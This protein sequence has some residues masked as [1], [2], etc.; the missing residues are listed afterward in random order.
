MASNR[1]VEALL[2]LWTAAG[3][4]LLHKRKSLSLTAGTQPLLSLKETV[5]LG[6]VVVVRMEIPGIASATRLYGSPDF[7]TF[8]SRGAEVSLVHEKDDLYRVENQGSNCALC[9]RLATLKGAPDTANAFFSDDY[10]TLLPGE[11]R[12]VNLIRKRG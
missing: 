3:Q 12:C 8:F 6:D 2:S 1:T 11:T 7:T 9:V 5:P 4:Q 10:L